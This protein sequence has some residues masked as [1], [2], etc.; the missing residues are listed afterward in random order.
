MVFPFDYMP[1][2]KKLVV[3]RKEHFWSLDETEEKAKPKLRLQIWENDTFSSD[4]FIGERE[5]D[6]SELDKPCQNSDHCG[7]EKKDP[8]LIG[9]T[10]DLFVQKSSRGWWACYKRDTTDP[11]APP[12]C[13]GKVEMTVELLAGYEAAAKPAGQGREDPNQHPVLEEPNRPATSFLW[14]TSPFKT[15]RYI[16]WRRYKWILLI[17]LILIIIG[18][19]LGIFFYSMPGYT[20]KKL[21]DV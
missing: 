20:V 5:L 3:K 7:K 16:I 9:Q 18:L 2:E 14:F 11:A 21:F 1:I 15:L 17:L 10:L 4:D 13:S 8:G 6:L 19:L 12:V